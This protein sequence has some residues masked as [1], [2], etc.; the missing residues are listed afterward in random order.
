[1]HLLG[2]QISRLRACKTLAQCQRCLHPPASTMRAADMA[3]ALAACFFAL[4]GMHQQTD[5]STCCRSATPEQMQVCRYTQCAT[6]QCFVVR[7][8]HHHS[9]CT[10]CNSRAKNLSEA[11]PVPAT[12]KS[13]CE[14]SLCLLPLPCCPLLL[15][16][17]LC[18]LHCTNCSAAHIRLGLGRQR[19]VSMMRHAH[20]G[21][22]T[23]WHACAC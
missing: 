20:S 12:R 15:A 6:S 23:R 10:M 13:C 18:V 14:Q 4:P 22:L 5:I 1:M 17:H 21:Q 9:C 11:A 2:R 3:I 19:Q 8:M 7:D 16:V